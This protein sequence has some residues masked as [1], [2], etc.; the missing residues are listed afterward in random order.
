MP[1]ELAYYQKRLANTTIGATT[2]RK[3]GAAGVVA[4]ARTFLRAMHLDAVG[5]LPTADAFAAH[6][7][8][9]T[10][11]LM[12]AL[13]PAGSSFGAARKAINLF[14]GET[15][16][17]RVVCQE[18]GLERIALWLEVPLDRMVAE[19]L[20]K[21]AKAQG[22]VLPAWLGIK[23]LTPE[24]SRRYQEFATVYAAGRGEGWLRIHVDLVAWGR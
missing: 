4:A 23:W 18:F 6:L 8:Q 24:D 9:Q 7:N 17:H 14:L 12:K 15:Y 5:S 20:H 16:Y 1:P 13:P 19:F 10:D 11:D 21:E 22:V 3:Q 2:L